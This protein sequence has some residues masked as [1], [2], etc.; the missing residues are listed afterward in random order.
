MFGSVTFLTGFL[1][2]EFSL[3]FTGFT[4]VILRLI[5][6]LSILSVTNLPP[7]YTITFKIQPVFPR[8]LFISSSWK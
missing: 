6:T 7:F 4:E 5:A 3:V 8:Y 2:E 1:L